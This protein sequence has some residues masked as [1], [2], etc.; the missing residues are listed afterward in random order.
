MGIILGGAGLGGVAWAPLLRYM[1]SRIGFRMTLRITGIIAALINSIS[2]LALKWEPSAVSRNQQDMQRRPRGLNLP[3]VNLKIV[4]TRAFAAHAIGAALQAAAYVTPTYFLSTYAK[5]LGYSSATGANLIAV[6]NA[7]NF[8]GKIIIGYLADRFGR[9]NALIVSTLLSGLVTLGLWLPS[10]LLL[11]ESTRRG[12]FL[13]FICSY[14]FTSSAYVSLFFTGLAEQFG[15]E[16]FDSI[17]GLLYMIRGFGTLVGTPV[18]GALIHTGGAG[19]MEG[20]V[21]F[22]ST[23]VMVGVLLMSATMFVI[24]ARVEHDLQHGWRLRG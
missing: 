13:C 17:N 8:I 15:A 6:T 18:A 14:G 9:L 4:R 1:N 16:N 20:I 7:C 5:T 3:R 23:I 19:G 11:D 21:N 12:L 22:E 10:S 2:A 24:W